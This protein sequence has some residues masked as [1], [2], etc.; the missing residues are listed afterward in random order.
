MYEFKCFK[1][2]PSPIRKN[3]YFLFIIII[4]LFFLQLLL[5]SWCKGDF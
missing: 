2:I 4:I 5:S 1:L 3:N